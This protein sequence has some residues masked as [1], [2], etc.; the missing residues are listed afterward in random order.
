MI[1]TRK[2]YLIVI[3]FLY[4]DDKTR[5]STLCGS[6][7]FRHRLNQISLSLQDK[8]S[9][10]FRQIY[11]ILRYSE[12]RHSGIHPVV[13]IFRQ[14]LE[15]FYLFFQFFYVFCVDLMLH[16]YHRKFIAVDKQNII[17]IS[18]IFCLVRFILTKKSFSDTLFMLGKIDAL[19]MRK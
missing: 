11:N 8:I 12:T 2:P 5:E 14:C 9:V 3:Y 18:D 6:H 4:S 10:F 15:I 1:Q 17:R 19:L 16:F 7:P 13:S